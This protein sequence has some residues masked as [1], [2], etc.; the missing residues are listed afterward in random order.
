MQKTVLFIIFMVLSSWQGSA[1][2]T[3][4]DVWTPLQFLVGR[5]AGTTHGEPGSGKV[6]RSYQFALKGKFL[7]ARAKPTP[8]LGRTNSVN[9]LRSQNPARTS[10][11]IRRTVS[12]V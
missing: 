9:V 12:G 11:C 8:S 4:P 3:A 1:A 6:E 10:R 7:Q 2:S 5:W